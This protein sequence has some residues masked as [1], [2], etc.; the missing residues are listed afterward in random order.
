MAK[1]SDLLFVVPHFRSTVQLDPPRIRM[2]L[3]GGH[4]SIT[5]VIFDHLKKSYINSTCLGK[6]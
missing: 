3:F 2:A 1:F 5:E 6:K 4:K